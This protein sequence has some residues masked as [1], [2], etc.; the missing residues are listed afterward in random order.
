MSEFKPKAYF[1]FWFRDYVTSNARAKMNWQQRAI[2]IELL[3]HCHMDNGL[4]NDRRLLIGKLGL[5]SD[6][7]K[8]DLDSILAEFEAHPQKEGWLMH[9]KTQAVLEDQEFVTARASKGGQARKARDNTTTPTTPKPVPNT[10]PAAAVAAVDV[11]DEDKA[12]LTRLFDKLAAEYPN[13]MAVSSAREIFWQK[14]G[15][16]K[17]TAATAAAV[18]QALVKAKVSKQWEKEDGRFVPGFSK[19]ISEERWLDNLAGN[20]PMRSSSSG[21]DPWAR[22]VPP[23]D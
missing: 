7:E 15:A 4:Q 17:I 8:A 14:V 21:R 16:G 2:Y 18:Y 1:P 13:A 19:W 12:I 9:P 20:E 22:Y 3:G 11:T 23:K 5:A 10:E 6:E